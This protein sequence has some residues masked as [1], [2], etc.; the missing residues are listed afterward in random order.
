MPEEEKTSLLVP[1]I[2]AKVQLWCLVHT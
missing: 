2:R 1:F